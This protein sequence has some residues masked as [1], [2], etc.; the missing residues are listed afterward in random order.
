MADLI[1]GQI[2]AM[3]PKYLKAREAY[4]TAKLDYE[5]IKE[6]MITV[7]KIPQTIKTVWGKIVRKKGA[8]KVEITC[9]LT[10]AKINELQAQIDQLKA[11]AVAK[12]KAKI[13]YNNDQINFYGA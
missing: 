5:K 2:E 1:Q 12:K 4:E 9:E 7:M 8:K 11:L 13:S 6:E 3:M 10:I